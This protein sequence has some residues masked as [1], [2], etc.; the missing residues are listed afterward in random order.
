[1]LIYVILPV[2]APLF[3][4]SLFWVGVLLA[5]N[6]IIRIFTLGA[7]ASLAERVGPRN[8][9]IAA[10]VT[11][12]VSTLIYGLATGPTILLIGR[13]LWGLSFASLTLV[14][15]SYAVADRSKAGTRVGLGRAIHSIGPALVAL[16]GPFLAIE[17]GAKF[18]FVI[19]GVAT[20]V[21]IPIAFFL[22]KE[23]RRTNPP[24]ARLIPKPKKFDLFLFTVG[25]TVDGVFAV[26]ITLT[27]AETS[28]IGTAMITGGVLIGIRRAMEAF[29]SPVGGILGDRYGAHRLL[30]MATIVMAV[31]FILLA[32][33]SAYTGGTLVVVGRAFIAALWPAETAIRNSREDTMHRLAV[34]QT[35]R[36][37][38]AAIGPLIVGSILTLMSLSDI[39]W[40]TVA[41]VIIGL[42]LQKRPTVT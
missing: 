15:F 21:S 27:V 33:G 23:A 24:K 19:L 5:A 36:D 11:S 39:Y 22:P 32:L 31:G 4:V 17:F 42:I 40:I 30:W 14:I 18:V 41:I 12:T 37:V 38:G 8:L 26:A 34:G 25:L 1:V 28:S 2:N 16:I 35:W 29:L 13:L 7:I 6:R 3:G 9:A 20:A 10:A